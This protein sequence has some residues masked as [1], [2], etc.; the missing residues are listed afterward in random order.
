MHRIRTN[1][2]LNTISQVLR[3]ITPFITTPY[4]ARVLGVENVGTFS[5]SYSIQSYFCLFAVLGTAA[6]G[7]RE[8]AC[9]RDDRSETSLI[10]WEIELLTVF[11]SLIAMFGWGIVIT[12]HPE[13]RILYILLTTYLLAS[14]LD[15]SWLYTGLELFP[16]IV[17][18]SVI[19]RLIE[20]VCIFVFVRSF[21]DLPIYCA[22]MGGGT[23]IGNV[24]LWLGIRRSID[25]IKI[26]DLHPFRHL[27]GTLVF[28]LP[29]IATT[30]YTVLDKTL[31]GVITK[32]SY[33]NGCYEQATKVIEIAKAITFTSLNTVLS[34][35][36]SYLFVNR[37]FSKIKDNLLLS[38]D[39]MLALGFG[40]TF[41]IASVSKRFVPI[42]FGA[43]YD[44][45][46]LLLKLL[47]PIIPVITVSNALGA[48]YYN[49]AGLRMKSSIYLLVGAVVNLILNLIL[50]PRFKSA[51]AIVASVVAEL[52]I[53]GLYL[54]NCDGYLKLI[55][56]LKLCYKKII[57]GTLMA[58]VI[59]VLYRFTNNTMGGLAEMVIL[60]GFTYVAMLVFFKDGA[61]KYIGKELL[62]KIHQS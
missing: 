27:K 42:F 10:F 15:I 29:T 1:F 60:G 17:A 13:N 11:T 61:A 19:V 30:I 39:I 28:F 34:P 51:G 31:I 36:S 53:T 55:Q 59:I 35:R 56:I 4:V 24:T 21:N 40:F 32:S 48:Q 62:K 12:L 44:G 14:M 47:S 26:Q 45:V 7:S 16:F 2:I 20:A 49:P 54:I 5:Y 25:F 37:D 43:G 33:E 38:V 52:V 8:I 3:I 46:V 6:Y 58:G 22:I 23:L 9:A 57:S 41:G 18:R 50:I